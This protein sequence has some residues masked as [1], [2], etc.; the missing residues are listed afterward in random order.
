[1]HACPRTCLHAC[2]LTAL[3]LLAAC[4]PDTGETSAASTDNATAVAR[5]ELARLQS[6]DADA[7]ARDI[8]RLE[9]ALSRNLMKSGGLDD[10]LGGEA[11]A[12]AALTALFLDY[13]RKARALRT[14]LPNAFVPANEGGAGSMGG[15]GWGGAA[16]STVLGGSQAETAAQAWERGQDRG[17]TNGHAE[18]DLLGGDSISVVWTADTVTLTTE[19]NA[20]VAGIKGKVK[21]TVNMKTCPDP[22]GRVRAEFESVS[23]LATGSG[24]ASTRL[25]ASVEGHVD[26]DANLIEGQ[27]DM[28]SS[29]QQ[30]TDRG[31]FVNVSDTISTSR[32]D[33]GSTVNGQSGSANQQDVQAAQFMARMGRFAAYQTMR[34]AQKAWQSGQ[35][36]DLQVRSDPAKRTGARPNT[37]YM[38]FAEPRAKSDGAPAGGTVTATLS[39]GNRL[40]PTGKVRA[41]AQFDYQNPEK[42]DQSASIDFE[43]RS[44]RGVGK[45]TLEFDTRRK[46]YSIDFAQCPGGGSERLRACD[47]S[48]P[49]TVTACGGMASVTHTPTSDKGG[50]W[51]FKFQGV[52]GFADSS[53]TYSLSGPEE[54]MTARYVSGR[55]C[56]HVGGRTICT[57]P[58]PSSVN[59]T[60]IDDC[61]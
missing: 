15:E 61:E 42:K 22:Q 13:E 23:S 35:C 54:T 45:A 58:K 46:S 16:A 9:F 28:E 38:L 34:A 37:A 60:R 7:T 21:T 26:D 18:S 43:S 1:M 2:L 3:L 17:E 36:I 29:A 50:H 56:G 57:T 48:K 30:S 52:G 14:E 44:K 49:F 12:D 59:W 53:G 5:A 55:V 10:A 27:G 39:G 4:S 40:N 32:G 47:V 20:N 33:V 11:N 51:T 41:D 19:V 31:D 25:S 24:N 6:Q 8:T